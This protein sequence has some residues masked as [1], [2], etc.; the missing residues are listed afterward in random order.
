MIPG[1]TRLVIKPEFSRSVT[2]DVARHGNMRLFE[3]F[4]HYDLEGYMFGSLAIGPL[5]VRHY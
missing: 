2:V 1:K 5:I 3:L 4:I